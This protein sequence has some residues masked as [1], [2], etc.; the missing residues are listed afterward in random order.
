MLSAS[1][2]VERFTP[3]AFYPLL[4]PNWDIMGNSRQTWWRCLSRTT[5]RESGGGAGCYQKRRQTQPWGWEATDG[6]SSFVVMKCTKP[7]LGNIPKTRLHFQPAVLFNVGRIRLKLRVEHGPR[8]SRGLFLLSFK[9]QD[10]IFL[11]HFD[12]SS[13]NWRVHFGCNF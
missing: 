2:W 1:C 7:C 4:Q 9:P 13:T 11:P 8:K 5:G 3:V 6:R 10:M 12:N